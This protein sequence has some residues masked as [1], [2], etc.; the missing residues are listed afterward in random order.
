VAV[1]LWQK[2]TEFP[3]KLIE[4]RCS[5]RLQSPQ[6]GLVL[7]VVSLGLKPKGPGCACCGGSSGSSDLLD[8][9]TPMSVNGEGEGGDEEEDLNSSL[10]PFSQAGQR[11]STD[12]QVRR[13]VGRPSA[14][15]LHRGAL[16]NPTLHV[17]A[18]VAAF[19]VQFHTYRHQQQ[20]GICSGPTA[21][22]C[23]GCN[24]LHTI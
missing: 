11:I 17:F 10:D 16:A 9:F 7:I 12:R 24:G 15:P 1:S 22:T 2:K 3:Q 19:L 14:P 18:A 6:A 8:G 21:T 20:V 4:L 5:S 13:H 23:A